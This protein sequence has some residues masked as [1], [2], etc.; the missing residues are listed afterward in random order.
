MST[1]IVIN[2]N[3]LFTIILYN[4]FNGGVIIMTDFASRLKKLRKQ[5]GLNQTQLAKRI[6]V[7]KSLVS[8]YENQDRSPSPE[9]LIKLSKIFHVSTDYLLGLESEQVLNVSNL[10]EDD[11]EFVKLTIEKLSKKDNKQ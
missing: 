2:F 5:M 11:I 9:I 8:Y 3:H 7:S 10:S 4:V 1:D 6:G